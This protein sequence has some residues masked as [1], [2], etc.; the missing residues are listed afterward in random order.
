M[1]GLTGRNPQVTCK[2]RMRPKATLIK[3]TLGSI[4]RIADGSRYIVC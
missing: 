4:D 3:S 1:I 2:E